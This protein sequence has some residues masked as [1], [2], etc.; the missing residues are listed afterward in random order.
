MTDER[1]IVISGKVTDFD[2]NPLQNALVEI[3]NDRFKTIYKT[4]TN[5]NGEYEICVKKGLYLA[6]M[7]CKDYKTKYLEYWAWNIPAN[8][9]LQFN[10]RIDGIE[11]YA[12]NAFMPQ[13]AY[14]SL[15][16]Y[17]RPM[18][19]KRFHNTENTDTPKK[20]GV[21]GISPTLSLNDIE[22]KIDGKPV[23]ILELNRVEEYAGGLTSII[24]YLIQSTLPKK[25]IIAYLIQAVLP[26]KIPENKKDS[27]Y[28]RIDIT[29]RDTQTRER[30]EGCLFWKR[31]ETEVTT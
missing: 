18:S 11:V 25:S 16:I 28:F 17:F 9:D 6:L 30:G 7:A 19:L 31:Q 12:M 27:E 22:L 20:T 2:N 26:I 23:K 1:K 10:P 21:I 4:C 29:L 13:G 24:A 8:Q 14:P 15:M 3:K 5:E